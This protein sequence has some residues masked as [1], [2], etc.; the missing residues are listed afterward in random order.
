MPK[1]S[2][3][4]SLLLI[5][6]LFMRSEAAA[7][8]P[9]TSRPLDAATVARRPAPGTVVPGGIEF[10]HDGKAV[11]Y[12]KSE[13][14]SLDRVLWRAEVDG[15]TPPRIVARPPG[16]GNTDANVSPEEAL[17]RER[18]R[19]VDTGITSAVRAA[20]ADV[21]VFPLNGDLYL[22]RGTGPLERLTE[23]EA[24]EIDPRPSPDGSKVAFIRERELYVLDL[25]TRKETRL[26]QG[27][28]D[29]I[30]H[31]LAAFMAQEEMDRQTGYWW[32]PDGRS[33]AYQETDERP[34][35]LFSIV[36]DGADRPSVETHR[37]PF[38]GAKNALVRL[39]VVPVEGGETRW[40]D[41]D[42]PER[43]YYLA[44]VAWES[45][46]NLLVQRL[47]RDQ[48]ELKLF[49]VD[50]R[51]GQTTLLLEEKAPTWVNLHDDLKTI[52]GTGEFVWA[53][54]R[55]GFKHLEL[56]DKHG[57][58]VRTLT[59]G[60]WAVDGV[61]G[62]DAKRREVWF[63]SGKDDVLGAKL[64]RVSLDGG[65][66]ACIT[67][68]DGTHKI[69]V[70]DDGETF[71][72]TFS[73]AKTPPLTTL[74]DRSGKV[75]QTLDDAGHDP[76]LEGLSLVPPEFFEFPS[77]DGVTFHGAYYE[78]RSKALG[79]KAPLIVM[80]YGGPHVQ[81][82]TDSWAMTA[83]L[84][85]QYFAQLGFA[86]WKMDNRGSARRGHAF[87]AALHKSLGSIEVQDQVN[88]VEFITSKKPEVDASR[89]GVNGRSYGGYMTLR[90]LTEAPDVFRAGVAEAPVTDWDG[91]DSTYTERYMGLPE[92]NTEGYSRAS[93]L[94]RVGNLKGKLL[95]IHGLIDE[96]VHFRHTAR[97]VSALVAAGKPF[98]VLPMPEERHSSRKPESRTHEVER[99]T[100]FFLDALAL[101]ER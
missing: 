94:S 70:S 29:T 16:A 54:E 82:V 53:S 6:G 18:M 69:V 3:V 2:R 1:P 34:V 26:S 97:L 91:Y 43:E 81:Y 75:L 27:A 59:E 33:I 72:D 44:R 23:S 9:D 83:D 31:G 62:L 51:N 56:R 63:A 98:E 5:L 90:C 24:P 41:F 66:I 28:T 30:S 58:L 42:E 93:V 21:T 55:T 78:P 101:P 89:I 85:A 7:D 14:N 99:L 68:E 48:K 20:K 65:P 76:R 32:S 50:A 10:T 15:K 17:R 96:N 11:V 77:R 57:D 86:V 92:K 37:Y 38:P 95:V 80:L 49:R 84:R 47:L 67:P 88:G 74:R 40:L 60:P 64:Y 8:P 73:T 13:A 35:A 12:L 79:E 87:E 100:G 52:P 61:V 4:A 22:Q 36:H 46:K 25:A 39:G 19:Q 71:V 45:P